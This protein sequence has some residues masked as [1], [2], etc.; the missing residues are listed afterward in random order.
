MGSRHNP[1]PTVY[2]HSL[3]YL[4]GLFCSIPKPK[5]LDTLSDV[6]SWSLQNTVAS[7]FVLAYKIL[8]K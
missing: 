8:R 5:H 2:F 4:K 1:I 3:L 6:V 7:E